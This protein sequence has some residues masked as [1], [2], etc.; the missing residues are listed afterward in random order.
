MAN[1]LGVKSIDEIKEKKVPLKIAIG[2][3]G[4][5]DETAA[6]MILDYHGLSAKTIKS[7]GGNVLLLQYG[8]QVK[9]IKDRQADAYINMMP[10][11]AP[12]VQ[13]MILSRPLIMLPLD[14]KMAEEY[15]ANYAFSK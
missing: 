2:R 12:T 14:S 15:Q 11:P 5:I 8:E 7:W 4:S 3:A 10:I 6:N 1:D 13:E 9:K